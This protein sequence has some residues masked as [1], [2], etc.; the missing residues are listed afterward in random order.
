MN[1]RY[2]FYA[3]AF[4]FIFV[5]A[6]VLLSFSEVKIQEDHFTKIYFN[7]T[8]LEKNNEYGIKVNE[9][10]I[11]LNDSEYNVGDSFFINGKGY[12]IG[13]I[14]NDSIL[15]YN[16]TKKVNGLI[17]FEYTIENVEGSDKDYS[18]TILIDDKKIL[19]G[20]ESVR[21][22]EKKILYNE[23]KFN[24]AG[25]HRLSIILNTG[26]EIHFNFSSVK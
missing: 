26:A 14:N 21:S 18:Y 19:E 15:L 24:E 3:I 10:N 8:I 17:F 7:T 16:Y 13:M 11:T 20:K 9:G 1:E 2:F 22:N 25:D 6:F 12:T 23:I 4:S 5:S